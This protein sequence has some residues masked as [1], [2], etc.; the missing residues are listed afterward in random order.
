MVIKDV[1]DF[2]LN[3]DMEVEFFISS[4]R[5]FQYLG[6]IAFIERLSECV[7]NKLLFEFLVLCS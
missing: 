3:D 1:L 2:D 6:A 7:T 4:G 5:E